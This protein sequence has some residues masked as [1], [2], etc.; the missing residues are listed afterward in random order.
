MWLNFSRSV[1][2]CTCTYFLPPMSLGL[3]IGIF[4]T[5][6]ICKMWAQLG[7][8]VLILIFIS[9]CIFTIWQYYLTI[10][11]VISQ[12]EENIFFFSNET[13]WAINSMGHH[14]T[15]I[16]IT[17]IL[18]SRLCVNYTPPYSK[19]GKIAQKPTVLSWALP[20]AVWT[21]DIDALSNNVT[22]SCQSFGAK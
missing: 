6:F 22:T 11:H 13:A 1:S 5:R 12:K 7:V 3:L 18:Q 19:K 2:K 21:G 9:I 8:E 16:L 20:V 15:L 10:V 17:S 4:L 14:Q